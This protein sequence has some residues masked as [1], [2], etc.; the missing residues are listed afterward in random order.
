MRPPRDVSVSATEQ[1][2]TDLLRYACGSRFHNAGCE[3]CTCYSQLPPALA[4]LTRRP[5]K[6]PNLDRPA[7]LEQL[8]SIPCFRKPEG[9]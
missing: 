5:D 4:L 9:P 8:L 3:V 2:P 6:A 1:A 7:T